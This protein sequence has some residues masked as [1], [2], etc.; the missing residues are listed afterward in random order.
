MARLDIELLF[1]NISTDEIINNE[2]E[3][4]FLT[5][6]I[7]RN[8]LRVLDLLL[9]L[10]TSEFIFDIMLYKQ[11]D[12]VATSLPL[13]PTLA[14]AFL[15]HYEQIWLNLLYREDVLTTGLFCFNSK[16]H[17]LLFVEHLISLTRHKNLKLTFDFEQHNSFPF[18]DVKVTLEV[19]PLLMGFLRTL[20]V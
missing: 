15:C 13:G 9:T 11:I 18:L 1:I 14:I 2:V 10:A 5:I 17:L 4:Y 12:K 7:T 8:S 19:Q 20:T 6:R 3:I 16:Y